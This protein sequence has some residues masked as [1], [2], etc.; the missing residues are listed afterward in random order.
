MPFRRLIKEL[1]RDSANLELIY[2]E[3]GIKADEVPS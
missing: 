3:F 2:R 1:I